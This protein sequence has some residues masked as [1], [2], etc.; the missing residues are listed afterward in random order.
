MRNSNEFFKGMITTQ[1]IWMKSS[2]L[3]NYCSQFAVCL[4]ILQKTFIS[5]FVY[6]HYIF[7]VCMVDFC[8]CLSVD[9]IVIVYP[10]MF[11]HAVSLHYSFEWETKEC[12]HQLVLIWIECGNNRHRVHIHRH[13][14]TVHTCVNLCTLH[15]TDVTCACM[16]N[17]AEAIIC[18]LDTFNLTRRQL[19]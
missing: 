10:I 12:C 1:L 8:C 4:F 2:Q 19:Q 6:H 13:E 9:L 17:H 16:Q 5:F 18:G 15:Y 11:F 7:S 3:F 14:Y